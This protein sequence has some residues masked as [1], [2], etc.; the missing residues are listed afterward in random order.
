M[1][2]DCLKISTK[3]MNFFT[4]TEHGTKRQKASALQIVYDFTKCA[5]KIATNFSWSATNLILS[6]QLSSSTGEKL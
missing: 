1:F 2:I 5:V 6:H 4:R 3:N